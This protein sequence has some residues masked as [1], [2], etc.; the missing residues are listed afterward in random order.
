LVIARSLSEKLGEKLIPIVPLLK[1]NVIE[2]DADVNGLVFPIYDFK[3]PPI[4]QSF[5]YSKPE[6]T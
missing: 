1:K 5:R 3:A 4:I 2:N 6:T